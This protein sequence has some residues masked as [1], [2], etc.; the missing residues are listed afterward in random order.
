[1]TSSTIHGVLLA[2][3]TGL[4]AL[5]QGRPNPE[6]LLA[7]QRKAM[8]A[9]AFMDGTW[10]GSAWTLLPTGEKHTVTQ[11]ERVGPM[12]DGAIKVVEGKGYGSDGKMAFNA[13]ATISYNASTKV[14]SMRSHAQGM[15]GDFVLTPNPD[16]FVW[17]IPAGPMVIRY[18][19]TIK[20]GTWKE[21]GDRIMP[22]KEPVRF[23]EMNMKR[24]GDSSW[25]A[26]GAVGPK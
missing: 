9:L 8:A 12:L 6:V 18:T 21:V 19:A 2:L 10:R 24:I 7:E 25:P 11:T 16:G 22:G 1:M 26:A 5:A 23:L 4:P 15:A 3:A 17:E 13:F 20:D 14:F